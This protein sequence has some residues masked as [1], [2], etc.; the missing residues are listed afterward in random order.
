VSAAVLL[1]QR[2][3]PSPPADDKST[4][5]EDQAGN[6]RPY[7]R[8][9]NRNGDEGGGEGRIVDSAIAGIARYGDVRSGDIQKKKKKVTVHA[10]AECRLDVSYIDQLRAIGF[11]TKTRVKLLS[12][13]L[14]VRSALD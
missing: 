11:R 4:A 2:W 5:Y 14:F 3:T 10:I 6:P 8:T 12:S 7:C 9:R 1:D 13:C